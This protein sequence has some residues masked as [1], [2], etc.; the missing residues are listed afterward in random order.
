MSLAVIHSRALQ[1]GVELS[2]EADPYERAD[3]ST[4]WIRWSVAPW[5]TMSWTPRARSSALRGVTV[6]ACSTSVAPGFAT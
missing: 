1:E 6:A 5:R 3:G 4:E 2:H